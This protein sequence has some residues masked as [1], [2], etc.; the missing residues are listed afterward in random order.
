MVL[1]P[2]YFARR[3]TAKLTDNDTVVLADFENKTGDAVLDDAL[4][5]ALAMELEQHG[6]HLGQRTGR[7]HQQGRCSEGSDSSSCWDDTP[8]WSP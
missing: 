1:T 2:I 7:G 4:K 6:R 3:G 5:K 8:D